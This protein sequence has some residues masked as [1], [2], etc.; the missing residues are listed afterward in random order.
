MT[1]SLRDVSK[2]RPRFHVLVVVTATAPHV[3]P[4]GLT[5]GGRIARGC[6]CTGRAE[7]SGVRHQCPSENDWAHNH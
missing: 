3:R 1:A 5:V 6:R 2:A 7:L 4:A